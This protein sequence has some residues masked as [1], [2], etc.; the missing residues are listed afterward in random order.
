MRCILRAI[1]TARSSIRSELRQLQHKVDKI[2]STL[3]DAQVAQAA[4]DALISKLA[5][6]IL[7][8]LATIPGVTPEQ[9][10]VIDDVVAHAGKINDALT[11]V[12][13]TVA[14]DT[15]PAA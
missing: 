7:A 5:A 10:A 13:A 11:S 15:P 3:A 14:V 9:Q 4:T 6:D 12:D 2:M 1:A 8:K